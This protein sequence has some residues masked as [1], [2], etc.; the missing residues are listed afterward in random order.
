[1]L[2]S[3]QTQYL[4]KPGV[5]MITRSLKELQEIKKAFEIMD[6]L[7]DLYNDVPPHLWT[8]EQ[9]EFATEKFKKI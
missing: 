2:V 1:M 3:K 7:E 4:P 9:L 5:M 8:D 6:A